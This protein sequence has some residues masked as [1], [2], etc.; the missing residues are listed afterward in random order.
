SAITSIRT[1]L[2]TAIEVVDSIHGRVADASGGESPNQRIERA[3]QLAL[4]VVSTLDSIESRLEKLADGLSAIQSPVQDLKP[5]TQWWIQ[6]SSIALTLLILL[7]AA[8]Q[9]SL[10]WQSWNA[11]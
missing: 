11:S 5:R 8:G 2:A 6:I 7:M 3:A 9:G 1:Q 10:C 4:G